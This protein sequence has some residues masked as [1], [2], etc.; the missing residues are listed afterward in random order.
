MASTRKILLPFLAVLLIQ[1][2]C[3]NGPTGPEVNHPR[4]YKWSADTL[5][6][7]AGQVLMDGIWGTSANN[8]YAVGHGWGSARTMWHFDGS[9][10]TNVKLGQ[11]EGG[12]FPA[13]FDL[14]AIHG[15]SADDIFAVGN[16]S[17]FIP[18]ISFIIHYD[19]TQ[20]TEHQAPSG[21]Y[22]LRAVWMN[23]ANDVWACGMNGTLLHY[24]GVAWSKDS[25]VVSPPEG[26]TFQL[27][28]I[29]R[30]PSGEM[31]LLGSAYEAVPPQMVL[32]WTYYFFRR[33]HDR[34]ILHDTFVRNEGE[35]DGKW[36]AS[37]LVV[38]PGGLLYSVDS[39]GL[40]QWNGTQWLRRYSHINNTAT[41]FG[42]GMN[43]LFVGGAFGLFAHYNGTDWYEYS[44]LV[45]HN[46][47][48]VGGWV[49]ET[50]AFILGW[51]D[52]EKTVVL[53]GR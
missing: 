22:S 24:N 33:E 49:N 23:A 39:Y 35:R 2:S 18:G 41:V 1:L 50:Q 52:G 6:I 47:H 38:L 34:W 36:G 19:G 26:S 14:A 4:N 30:I 15:L 43:N 32:R 29:A 8:L 3:K 28:S 48:Y 25:V 53:R 31:F 17:P 27:S 16:R 51:V 45:R 10:W 37:K 12:P 44:N 9:R 46:T 11:F 20:W 13:P 21:S 7:P 42:T 5:S 40:F